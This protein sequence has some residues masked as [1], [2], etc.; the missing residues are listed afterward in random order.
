MSAHRCHEATVKLLPLLL[1]EHLENEALGL[2]NRRFSPLS[3]ASV[4]PA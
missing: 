4:A 2:W 1:Q 3:G